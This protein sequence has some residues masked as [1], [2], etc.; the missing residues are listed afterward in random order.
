MRYKIDYSPESITALDQIAEYLAEKSAIAPFSVLGS[1]KKTVEES[2]ANMP[3]IG[4]VDEKRP[5][6]RRF[7]EEKYKY[8]IYYEIIEEKHI[9]RIAEVIHSSREKE[10]I[11]EKHDT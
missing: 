2:I 3:R 4:Q 10:P 11:L 6:L 1:I 9:V 7:V 8:W 5:R